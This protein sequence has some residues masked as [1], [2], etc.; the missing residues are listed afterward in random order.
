MRK[1]LR[2]GL[3]HVYTGDGKGKSTAALGQVLR[4]LG[5]GLKAYI[6]QFLKGKDSFSGEIGSLSQFHDNVKL[7]RYY[8]V[9][10]IFAPEVNVD[11]LS[12][13]VSEA[14]SEAQEAMVSGKYDIVVLDE[15][16]NAVAEGFVDIKTVTEFMASKPEAVELILTG[17]SAA[18]EIMDLADYVTEMRCVK[19]PF[20]RGIPARRGI[21][22]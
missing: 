5:H 4:A 6:V 8:Q 12:A 17:R 3:I 20:Q 2:T 14:L 11:Q 9:H 16:N 18:Q 15:I 1:N 10:P 13:S 21:E 7:I 22:F 19:H